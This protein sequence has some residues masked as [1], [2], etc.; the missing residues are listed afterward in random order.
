MASHSKWIKTPEAADLV[1]QGKAVRAGSDAHKR[2]MADLWDRVAKNFIYVVTAGAWFYRDAGSDRVPV[3]EAAAQKAVDLRFRSDKLVLTY[4]RTDG[5]VRAAY[6]APQLSQVTNAVLEESLGKHRSPIAKGE[7]PFKSLVVDFM[8]T[9]PNDGEIVELSDGNRAWNLWSKPGVWP[10]K[11]EKYVEPRWFLDVVDRIF[12]EYQKE[13]EYFLD[14]C[15]HLVC[16]PEIKMPISVLIVSSLN[17]AGK[18][19][20]AK[21]L[22]F[23][24]GSRN[25]RNLTADTLKSGFQS[26]AMGT[27][28][29]VIHELYEQGNYTFADRLKT[30]QS[31]DSVF[32]NIKYGPQQNTKNMVHFLAFSN[33][34]SPL[35]LEEGD[36]RWFTFASPQK[37]RAPQEWWDERWK[38]LKDPKTGL[39]YMR[40]LGSL[41]RFFETRMEAIDGQPGRF[42]PYERP[43]ETEH[44]ASLVEDSRS[45]FFMAVKAMV[46]TGK[47]PLADDAGYTNLLHIEAD[48]GNTFR[49]P[50]RGQARQDLE[51][52]GFTYERRKTGRFYRVPPGYQGRPE[53]P[54]PF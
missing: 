12:G 23:M 48:L 8:D 35:H 45:Q 47:V 19:F 39:P 30:W 49:M 41:T 33:R 20:I 25:Y 42:S 36:R 5:M 13:K 17:G 21:T 9:Y 16:R 44:K 14:W 52:L 28:L 46:D 27:T 54:S 4:G 53:A 31:E 29:A 32:V 43:P 11:P 18:G 1:D 26:F 2:I 51:A 50:P 22:E 10:T 6:E 37:E 3:K 24:V 7:G 34:S 15:A 38:F 40:A